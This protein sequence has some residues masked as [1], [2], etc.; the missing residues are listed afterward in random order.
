LFERELINADKLLSK[1][2]T[3]GI[4]CY[5]SSDNHCCFSS[6]TNDGLVYLYSKDKQENYQL[7]EFG[8]RKWSPIH[9]IIDMRNPEDESSFIV[10]V[11]NDEF[12]YPKLINFGVHRVKM[13]HYLQNYTFLS[14]QPDLLG[15]YKQKKFE[16]I[17]AASDITQTM[18]K[19]DLK[20][21]TRMSMMLNE[22]FFRINRISSQVHLYF[23]DENQSIDY[24]RLELAYIDPSTV[25]KNDTYFSVDYFAQL[26]RAMGVDNV[27]IKFTPSQI[28]MMSED[29]DSLRIGILRGKIM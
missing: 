7:K 22:K 29:E 21:L 20:S 4:V 2:D 8:I 24:A 11:E 25:W 18:P 28:I 9:S 16:L 23:G 17:R 19:E 5:P 12:G 26:Y 3:E 15:L 27:K 1:F 6:I 10:Q 13:T 14:N